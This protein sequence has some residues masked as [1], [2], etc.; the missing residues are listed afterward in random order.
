MLINLLKCK[1]YNFY[2]MGKNV[3]WRVCACL[4]VS[5]TS[6]SHKKRLC[7]CMRVSEV[8]HACLCCCCCRLTWTTIHLY[9]LIH[10]C[11]VQLLAPLR[12][13]RPCKTWI[14]CWMSNTNELLNILALPRGKKQ[15]GLM[16]QFHSGVVRQK[17]CQFLKE[18]WAFSRNATY[19]VLSTIRYCSWNLFKITFWL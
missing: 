14:L 6:L 12:L 9:E 10:C 13:Y 17:R 2:I 8:L 15:W 7:T 18:S 11:L 4:F 16:E 1:P 19:F 5:N 3:L